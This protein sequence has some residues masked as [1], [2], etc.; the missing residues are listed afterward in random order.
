MEPTWSPDGR[1]VMFSVWENGNTDLW[2]TTVDPS[3]TPQKFLATAADESGARFAPD[4][5]HVAYVSTE[6]GRSE[7]FVREFPGGQ[8]AHQVSV[9]GGERPHWSPR[10]DELFFV[11]NDTLM[12]A[13]IQRGADSDLSFAVPQPLFTAAKIGADAIDYDVAKDGKRFVV[14]RTLTRRE[15]R[16]VV[17]ENWVSRLPKR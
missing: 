16:A 3:S 2:F 10:G 1:T 9:N 7:I 14:V 6:S 11:A 4:G 8:R 5:R 12:G 17:V 13:A 15:R